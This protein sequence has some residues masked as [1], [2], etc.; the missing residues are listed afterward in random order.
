MTQSSTVTRILLVNV[1]P[2]EARNLEWCGFRL[3][4]Y[5]CSLILP[6]SGELSPIELQLAQM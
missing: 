5:W 3:A 6:G 2:S 4:Q 1:I